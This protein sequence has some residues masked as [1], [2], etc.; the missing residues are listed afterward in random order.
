[1]RS[2]YAAIAAI[3]LLALT[4]DAQAQGVAGPVVRADVAGTLG[5]LNADKSELDTNQRNDW[6]NQSL[7]GGAGLG[8][9]WTD[10]WK[11]EIEAGA[12][13]SAEL[14]SYA[15][16]VIAGRTYTVYS[17]HT[18]S[19][20]RLAIGQ[21]Y[22]FFRNVWFHPFLGAGLDLTWERS[23]RRDEIVQSLPPPTL[24]YS[25]RTELLVRPF[26]TIG[27]KT[28]F[29]SRAFFRSDMKVAF[30]KGIDEALLRF[31]FGVDF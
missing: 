24:T 29:T 16:T 7:Y 27:F 13:T 25:T 11:T 8:W 30:D 6:Y 5:W 22:Q 28:Y 19:T 21:Q 20:S 10:H 17:R 9:Y 15:P 4:G 2:P 3:A 26:A 14:Y 23:N 1:M 12:S 31:G 18:F